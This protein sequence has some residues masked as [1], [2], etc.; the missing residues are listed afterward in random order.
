MNEVLLQSYSKVNIGLKV[1][2]SIDLEETTNLVIFR[3]INFYSQTSYACATGI[4]YAHKGHKVLQKAIE[5]IV[6]NVKNNFFG[7]TPL[8]PTGPSLW[9]RAIANVGIDENT[10]IGDFIELT[11]NFK[12]KNKF[13]RNL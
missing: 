2:K 4:I 11:P 9:G 1:V 5:M 7:Q 12:K 3:D 8:C 10:I 6:E 13:K